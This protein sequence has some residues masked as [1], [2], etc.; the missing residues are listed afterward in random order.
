MVGPR[1]KRF[2]RTA[3][4]LCKLNGIEADD[5]TVKTV[6]AIAAD[7][8]LRVS[9]Y[10]YDLG[11]KVPDEVMP[12]AEEIVNIAGAMVS[13]F[14]LDEKL[15][16]MCDSWGMDADNIDFIPEIMESVYVTFKHRVMEIQLEKAGEQ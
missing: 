10:S 11:Y 1:R 16:A 7:H 8:Y 14:L 5:D 4:D 12:H 2:L 15:Q 13:M 6:A 9:E 3:K